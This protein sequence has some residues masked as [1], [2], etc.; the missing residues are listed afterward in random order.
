MLL[1]MFPLGGLLMLAACTT[2]AMPPAT[3][4]CNAQGAQAYVGKVATAVTVEAARKAAGAALAR[5]IKPDQMVTMEYLEG[6]LNVD[7]DAAN[8]ITGF[9]CG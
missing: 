4:Q 3:G 9:R 8:V 6:R 5:T 1:R 7:V 2:P